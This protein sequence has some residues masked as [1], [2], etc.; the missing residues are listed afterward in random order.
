MDD[1][2][3]LHELKVMAQAVVTMEQGL[4]RIDLLELEI[5]AV[6]AGY[7]EQI[8]TFKNA[9]CVLL[10]GV[11]AYSGFEY[12]FSDQDSAETILEPIKSK[13]KDRGMK[14]IDQ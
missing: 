4:K 9:I 7:K 2:H 5:L 12:L 11:G 3:L 6:K 1:S 14:C 13:K 8:N 10:G